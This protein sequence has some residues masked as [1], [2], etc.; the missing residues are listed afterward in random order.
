MAK[1]QFSCAELQEVPQN[2]LLDW[3]SLVTGGMVGEGVGMTGVFA[4]SIISYKL[5]LFKRN[6]AK[7]AWLRIA[8]ETNTFLRAL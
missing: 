1:E 3:S 4:F 5:Q 7:M 2:L 6:V 8:Q